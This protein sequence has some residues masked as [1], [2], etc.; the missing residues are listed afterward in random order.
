MEMEVTD[1]HTYTHTHLHTHR[2]RGSL[3]GLET[4]PLT[5]SVGACVRIGKEERIRDDLTLE[6]L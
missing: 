4:F 5:L 6:E 3:P 2:Q 1:T